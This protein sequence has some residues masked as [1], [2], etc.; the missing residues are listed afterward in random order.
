MLSP[1]SKS[2]IIKVR[3]VK[4]GVIGSTSAGE[5]ILRTGP[6]IMPIEIRSKLL[7]SPVFLN[8]KFAKKPIPIIANTIEK[9]AERR[10]GLCRN[11][12]M[13]CVD[14]VAG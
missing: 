3:V 5:N 10:S 7:G 13:N 9:K 2:I 12:K 4:K 6:K 11:N 1:P 8:S 14:Y